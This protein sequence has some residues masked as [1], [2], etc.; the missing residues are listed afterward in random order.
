MRR[1]HRRPAQGSVVA[2]D[3]HVDAWLERAD[4][5]HDLLRRPTLERHDREPDDVGRV[6][7]HESSNG[8]G[9]TLLR[10][11]E[12]GDR[13]VVVRIDIARQ[14]R[15]RSVRQPHRDRGRVLERV[16]HGEQ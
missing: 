4:E 13:G 9:Q 3:H 10:E 7:H 12:V 8:A 1:L 15:K 11:D 14:R 2:A 16:G 6:V 5:R